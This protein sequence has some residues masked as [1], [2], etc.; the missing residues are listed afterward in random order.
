MLPSRL[1]PQAEG[2]Q[3]ALTQ[4]AKVASCP[5]KLEGNL[6]QI[7]KVSYIKLMTKILALYISVISVQ[8]DFS[9]GGGGVL[10]VPWSTA[11]MTLAGPGPSPKSPEHHL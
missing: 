4:M 2:V 11:G 3:V 7:P 8:M 1:S 6:M 9:E 10:H 5:V